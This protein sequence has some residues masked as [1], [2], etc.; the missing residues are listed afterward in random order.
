MY[1]DVASGGLHKLETS[2]KT[3]VRAADSACR[4]INSGL[5]L[6]LPN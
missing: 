2:P 5:M 6:N 4:V 3:I 1:G